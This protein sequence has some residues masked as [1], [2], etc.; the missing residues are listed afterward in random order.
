[1]CT[2]CTGMLVKAHGLHNQEDTAILPARFLPSRFPLSRGREIG[3]ATW[4]ERRER[5]R[6]RKS[7]RERVRERERDI[8]L[9]GLER[10]LRGAVLPPR[11]G[12]AAKIVCFQLIFAEQA[13]VTYVCVYIYI[14]T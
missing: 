3:R 10:N 8:G 5:E 9:P 14:Y 6:G 4:R 13:D 1:M 7:E 2:G 12:A 11:P